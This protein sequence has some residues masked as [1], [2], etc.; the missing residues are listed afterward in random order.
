MGSTVPTVR[1]P[2]TDVHE[3]GSTWVFNENRSWRPIR[4]GTGLCNRTPGLP[5]DNISIISHSQSSFTHLAGLAG[6]RKG[7]GFEHNH[8]LQRAGTSHPY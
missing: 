5:S 6:I 7:F 4:Q 2:E 1:K 8:Y 3:Q